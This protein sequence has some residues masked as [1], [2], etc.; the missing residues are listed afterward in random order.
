MITAAN[1]DFDQHLIV[2]LIP[3]KERDKQHIEIE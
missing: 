1:L 2:D 3:G